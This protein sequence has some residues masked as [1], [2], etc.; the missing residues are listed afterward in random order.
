M[1]LLRVSAFVSLV[2]CAATNAW[3]QYGLYG[4]PEMLRLQPVPAAATTNNTFVAPSAYQAEPASAGPVAS[5]AALS[6]TPDYSQP[7]QANV[8]PGMPAVPAVPENSAPLGLAVTGQPSPGQ[9]PAAYPGYQPS[10]LPSLQ[11]GCAA[12]NGGAGCGVYSGPVNQYQQ[13]ASGMGC[14]ACNGCQWYGSVL[15]LLMT[16]DRG[17]KLWTTYENGNASNQIMNTQDASVG[18]EWGAE[19]TFGRSFCCNQYAVE[20]TYW[21]L[22]EFQGFASASEPVSPVDPFGLVSTPL[23]TGLMLF[24]GTGAN[25]WFNNAEEHRLW[26]TDVV[27][28]V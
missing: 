26:R 12:G 20:A 16:R 14:E 22:H 2:A 21:T 24:H 8:G 11:A 1:K 18:W 23:E 17:N 10:Y 27:H 13:A 5:N 7:V 9:T 4:A 15:A 28:N 25:G 3:A 19:I 6:A